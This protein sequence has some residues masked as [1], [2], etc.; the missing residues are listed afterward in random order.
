MKRILVTLAAM[1]FTLGGCS[2]PQ[3]L[4]GSRPMQFT[5]PNLEPH[6]ATYNH[7]LFSELKENAVSRT[8]A[9]QD[10]AKMQTFAKA[11]ELGEFAA[12]DALSRGGESGGNYLLL[13]GGGQW[14]AFGAGFLAA[15]DMANPKWDVVTGISTGAIQTLFVGAGQYQQMAK[16]Y[17]IEGENPASSNGLFGLLTKGSEYDLSNLRKLLEEKLDNNLLE[18]IAENPDEPELFIGMVKGQSTN[19]IIVHISAYIRDNL[20]IKGDPGKLTKTE[21]RD[22]ITGL[23]L[24]SSAIP[25]R[26][27]PIQI[28]TSPD[29]EYRTYMDGGVRSS[30][31]DRQA[32]DALETAQAMKL[33]R[34]A[35]LTGD[36][37]SK[38]ALAE[39]ADKAALADVTPPTLFAV[40]NGPTI[41]PSGDFDDAI[42]DDPDA[43][44]TAMR[45]YSILVN[46]NELASVTEMLSRYPS[47]QLNFVSA[48]G[49]NWMTDGSPKSR[50][51]CPERN[52]KVY[53]DQVFMQCLVTFGE[54]RRKNVNADT[55]GWRPFAPRT[56]EK[57][58][59]D[60]DALPSERA[61]QNAR[62]LLQ[63]KA[64]R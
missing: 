46:Q 1:A 26:L 44:V 62:A 15:P 49:Y 24:A 3:A 56:K 18:Q 28:R 53:F 19:L 6:M 17:R 37:C 21:I 11:R 63:M 35:G 22:C 33:C 40:R 8:V 32:I 61:F 45:G 39:Y 34:K 13:S 50:E 20:G 57:R 60:E 52:E 23:T 51:A 27:T 41:V 9:A 2:G 25:L 36:G 58:L 59:T 12:A 7:R 55:G 10:Q 43:Y 47:A 48:D 30:V 16:E 54:W 29:G 5:C 42:D 64:S 38:A 31:I 4:L 14:G